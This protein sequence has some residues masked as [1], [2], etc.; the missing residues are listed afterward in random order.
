M[1]RQGRKDSTTTKD[2]FE[3]QQKRMSDFHDKRQTT[4]MNHTQA[5]VQADSRIW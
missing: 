2:V 4:V 1:R 3:C 5:R